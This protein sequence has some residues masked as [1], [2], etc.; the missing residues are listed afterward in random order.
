MAKAKKPEEKKPEVKKPML[1]DVLVTIG[2]KK[3]EA[4]AEAKDTTTEDK[5]KTRLKEVLDA[6]TFKNKQVADV[7][8]LQSENKKL[9]DMISSQKKSSRGPS[10]AGRISGLQGLNP[11]LGQQFS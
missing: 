10:S 11:R 5:G 9:R 3:K 2:T 8:D 1:R 7:S 6:V 4:K